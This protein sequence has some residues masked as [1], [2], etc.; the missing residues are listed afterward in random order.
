LN[1]KEEYKNQ[2][3]WRN[4]D[5]YL[6]HIPFCEDDIVIDLGCSVGCVSHLFSQKVKGVIGIDLSKEFIAYC[7]ESKRSNETFICS[8]IAKFDFSSVGRFNGVWASFSLSYLNTP[9]ETLGSIYNT[10]VNGGW[11]ALVDVS[12]FISGNMSKKSAYYNALRE[13][14]LASYNSGVYDFNFGSKMSQLLSDSGFKVIYM[15][16]D[17]TDPELNFT[18]AASNEIIENWKARLARLKGMQVKLGSNYSEAYREIITSLS[19]QTHEKR[20]NVKFVVAQR[21]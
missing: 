20:G 17:V 7:Q 3:K 18:G 9:S 19:S 4:W 14:E 21:I 13:F 1:L 2:Q 10:I 15:D 16:N 12:C 8:D 5:Q 11:L 6:D